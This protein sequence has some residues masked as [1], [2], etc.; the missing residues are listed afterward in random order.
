LC[1]PGSPGDELQNLIERAVILS[2]DGV[3]PNS[4]NLNS[5]I[6]RVPPSHPSAQEHK[7]ATLSHQM[8]SADTV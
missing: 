6:T 5:E 8:T 7:G 4:S 3:L 2:D 1:N